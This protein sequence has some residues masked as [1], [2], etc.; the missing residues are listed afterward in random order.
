[1]VEDAIIVTKSIIS[2]IF[3]TKIYNMVTVW[4]KEIYL[5]IQVVAYAY[6]DGTDNRKME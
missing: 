1:M 6:S 3:I 2:I 4:D 5:S